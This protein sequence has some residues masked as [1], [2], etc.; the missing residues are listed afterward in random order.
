MNAAIFTKSAKGLILASGL[1]AASSVLG[2]AQDAPVALGSQATVPLSSYYVLPPTGTASLGGHS[3]DLSGGNLIQ[4]G[5]AQ[6]ATFNGSWSNAKGAYLLLNS[7]NTYLWYDQTVVG[8]VTITF[9]DGTTQS[10]DLMVGGNLREWRTGS[11]NTVSW[12]YD[13]AAAQVWLTTAQDGMGGGEA[14]IDML[15]ISL[16][17]KTATAIT[18]T[19]TNT[20]GALLIDLAGLTVDYVAPQPTPQPSPDCL[21]PGNSC[22]TP[23]AVNSQAE[24]WLPTGTVTARSTDTKHTNSAHQP[25]GTH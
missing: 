24:K 20:W 15:S 2:Y 10:T 3:F 21:R 5:N 18:V 16:P 14:V 4:L 25:H 7:A 9:S 13:T 12:I 1:I 19:N 17:G 23:A 22:N 6:S 8:S 11:G